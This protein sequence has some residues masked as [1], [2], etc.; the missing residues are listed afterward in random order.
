MKKVEKQSLNVHEIVKLNGRKSFQK[1]MYGHHKLVQHNT[2]PI[3]SVILFYLIF[4]KR[5]TFHTKLRN[6]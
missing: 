2:E 3:V 1:K 6:S 5:Q 4:V